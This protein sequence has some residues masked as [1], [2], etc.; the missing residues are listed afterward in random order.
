MATAEGVRSGRM[1]YRYLYPMDADYCRDGRSVDETCDCVLCREHSRAY[2]NHLDVYKRQA[3]HHVD[4]ALQ[5]FRNFNQFR[6]HAV[7]A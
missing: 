1:F 6:H 2:L 5:F 4:G 7:H 3:Q